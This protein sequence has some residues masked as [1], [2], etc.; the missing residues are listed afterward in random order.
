MMNVNLDMIRELLGL[1][2]DKWSSEYDVGQAHINMGKLTGDKGNAE[3][4][5]HYAF[6]CDVKRIVYGALKDLVCQLQSM[7]NPDEVKEISNES[8]QF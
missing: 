4:Y 7:Q 5:E 2:V 3:Y 8:E 1:Q 6:T